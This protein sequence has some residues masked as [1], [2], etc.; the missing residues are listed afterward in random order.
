MVFLFLQKK[1]FRNPQ[2]I[3]SQY[4]G[5]GFKTS[6]VCMIQSALLLSFIYV[7][8]AGMMVARNSFF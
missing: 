8:V 7:I 5:S 4:T 2:Y 3:S 6:D 1:L